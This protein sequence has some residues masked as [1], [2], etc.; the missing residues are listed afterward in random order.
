MFHLKFIIYRFVYILGDVLTLSS[1]FKNGNIIFSWDNPQKTYK[2]FFV[3][4]NNQRKWDEVSEPKYTVDNA[5]MFDC[6]SINVRA[7]HSVKDNKFTYNGELHAFC[8]HHYISR[9]SKNYL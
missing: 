7:E 5:L 2:Y 4:I 3:I 6:I 9:F 1:S 8:L